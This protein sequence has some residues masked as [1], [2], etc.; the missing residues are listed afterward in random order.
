MAKL[1]EHQPERVCG[2][3]VCD[4]SAGTGLVGASLP[5]TSVSRATAQVYKHA[6]I[7]RGNKFASSC[8]T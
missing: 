8:P 6:H 5:A 3:R 7:S 1:L 4:L 2:K